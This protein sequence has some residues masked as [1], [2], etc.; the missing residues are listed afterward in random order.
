MMP[1]GRTHPVETDGHGRRLQTLAPPE[2]AEAAGRVPPVPARW[3]HNSQ[4]YLL[5]RNRPKGDHHSAND[6]RVPAE[7]GRPLNTTVR[8]R[9]GVAPRAWANRWELHATRVSLA[10]AR[11]QP[12][13][14]QPF[15]MERPMRTTLTSIP[16]LAGTR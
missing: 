3:P 12:G 1:A 6:T 13:R 2:G 11:H 7:P 5:D 8:T 15:G 10:T 9:L 14:T 4:R 16:V